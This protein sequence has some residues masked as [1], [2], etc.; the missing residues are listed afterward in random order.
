MRVAIMQPYFYPYLGYFRLLSQ[1]DLFILL[2]SVQFPRRGRVHRAPVVDGKTQEGWLTLPLIKTPRDSLIS[3]QGFA[4]TARRDL[5]DRVAALPWLNQPQSP[6]GARI[7]ALILNPNAGVQTGVN[8]EVQTGVQTEAQ[9]GAETGLVDYLECHLRL[10]ATLLG[11]TPKI[12]RSSRFAVPENLRGPD[13]ILH[14]ARQAGASTY[15]N[16]PGG[17]DL[18]QSAPFA[19]AG[20]RLDFL[21]PYQGRHFHLLQALCRG[22]AAS[23]AQCLQQEP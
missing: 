9:I 18:Y 22:E 20:I 7:R 1:T 8:T 3:Q 5:Q 15:V 10:C 12:V 23:L 21:P 6:D 16:A 14:L 17:R 11:L 4:P 13:R 2:D 19:K